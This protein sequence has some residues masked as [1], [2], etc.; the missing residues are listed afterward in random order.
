MERPYPLRACNVSDG[1]ESVLDLGCGSGEPIA[2]FFI[3]RGLEL[4]DVDFSTEMLKIGRERFPDAHWIHADMRGL[5]LDQTFDIV[6]AW[7]SFFH[8]SPRD[9]RSMFPIFRKHL[10]IA[11]RAT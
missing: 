2:R 8:L 6:V 10:R 11:R 3:E 7:D 4:T 9:Q 5:D 1:A